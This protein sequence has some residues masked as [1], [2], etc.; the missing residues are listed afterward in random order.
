M[1]L[2]DRIFRP[3]K[4]VKSQN[5]LNKGV[6]FLE[7]NNYRSAFTDWKG[8]IYERELIRA[9]IDARARH[10][11]KLKDLFSVKLCDGCERNARFRRNHRYISVLIR[12][13]AMPVHYDHF[14][15]HVFEGSKSCVSF[16]KKFF[17]FY[18][19]SAVSQSKCL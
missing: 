13:E 3:D 12:P 9:A 5:A 17:C 14:S 6:R 4:A 1:N 19:C 2:F 16:F 15:V 10:I 8:E 18:H 11:S 7:L